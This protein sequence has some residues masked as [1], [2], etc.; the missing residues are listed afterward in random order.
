MEA[1]QK[2]ADRVAKGVTFCDDCVKVC[3]FRGIV[4]DC[5]G[6]ILNVPKE[7]EKP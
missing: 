5:D 7:S 3:K 4:W 6:K 1:L 2:V